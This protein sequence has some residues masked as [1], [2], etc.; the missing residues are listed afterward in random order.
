VTI[1]V[2]DGARTPFGRFMG[3]LKRVSAVD[4]GAIVARTAVARAEVDPQRVGAVVFGNVIQSSADAVYLAR[5]V[6]LRAGLP[7][8]TP[9]L[10]VNRLCGSGLQAVVSAAQALLGNEAQWAVAGGTESMSQAPHVLRG[11]REG[12]GLGGG[13]VGDSLWDCL[14][15]VDC[16]C[17]M[18][19]TAENI[20]DD[21]Q[22]SRQEQD[23][24]SLLSHQRALAARE[25]FAAEIV[26]VGEV[27][28]DEHPRLTSVEKLASLKPAF[29]QG[30]RVTAGN[31]SG[32]NDGASAVVLTTD[33]GLKA[34]GRPALGAIRSW[35]VVGVDPTRMGLGPVSAIQLALARAHL[36]LT[37]IDLFEV[38]EA[39]A[40]QYLGVERLLGL[41]REQTNVNGGAIA[42]GHP[43]GAS[44]ARLLLTLL[45]ELRRRQQKF[46]VAAL[47]IGGGQGI[48]M[49]VERGE[50]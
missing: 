35:A 47:C 27:T 24:F 16:G 20:A 37:D 13:Q 18:A 49:V 46:G 10:T 31:A 17:S 50:G 48:A 32:I 22:I 44:G 41:P 28:E 12:W 38:N 14:T 36:A 43:V 3:G 34:A 23:E 45:Y 25:R 33:A 40:A 4:L 11:T 1:H 42:L 2:V 19:E 7:V 26:P 39:F 30:G 6:A 21:L 5:H 8:A 29:R 9:A 15:D